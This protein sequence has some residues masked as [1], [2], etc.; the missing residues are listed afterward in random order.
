VDEVFQV[1]ARKLVERRAD[2][3]RERAY[4]SQDPYT[5]TG[6]GGVDPNLAGAGEKSKGGKCC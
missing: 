4:G 2:I 3:E 1:I 5:R 6:N